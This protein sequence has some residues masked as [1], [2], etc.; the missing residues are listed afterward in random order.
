M[1]ASLQ[2]HTSLK[3]KESFRYANVRKA[4]YRGTKTMRNIILTINI[5]SVFKFCVIWGIFLTWFADAL[6]FDMMIKTDYKDG[7]NTVQDLIDRGMSLGI[8]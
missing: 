7:V 3:E 2:V 6:L 1:G 8:I 4:S 5:M